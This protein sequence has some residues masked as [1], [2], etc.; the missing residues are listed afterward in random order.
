MREWDG[1]NRSELTNDSGFSPQ[2]V[3]WQESCDIFGEVRG[4]FHPGLVV[5]AR[6]GTEQAVRKSH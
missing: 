5:P 2:V 4:Q 6:L 3:R 1:E